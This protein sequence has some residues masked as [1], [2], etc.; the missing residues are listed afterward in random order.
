MVPPKT[1]PIS[2]NGIVVV[3]KVE[4]FIAAGCSTSAGTFLVTDKM[5]DSLEELVKRAE[6]LG[7]MR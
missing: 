7:L 3:G 5:L 4:Y 2:K 1:F 6:R